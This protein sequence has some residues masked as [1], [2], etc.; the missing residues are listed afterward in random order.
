[1]SK[2]TFVQAPGRQPEGPRGV[3]RRRAIVAALGALC[4]P[5]WSHALAPQAAG[6]ASDASGVPLDSSGTR[7]ARA[8]FTDLELQTHEGRT[9]KFYSDLL[10][11]RSVLINIIYTHCTDACPMITQQLEAVRRKLPQ[12]LFGTRLQFVTLSSDPARDTP[13]LLKAFARKQGVDMP[14]W[15]FVTGKPAHIE[16][17]LKRLGQF[18]QHVESHSTLLLAGNVP[19]KRWSKMR[20]NAPVDA[21]VAR[22]QQIVDG[23]DALAGR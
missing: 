1:L 15:H 4:T 9:V 21:I 6:R 13:Q 11:G 5:A 7:D 19:A 23:S 20:A 12:G 3:E 8:Y 16:A 2:Q 22:L 14:G 17:I 18:S 10:E